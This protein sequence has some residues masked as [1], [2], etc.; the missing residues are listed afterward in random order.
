MA[1]VYLTCFPLL[2]FTWHVFR[3]C[4]LLDMFSMAVVY[5]TCF[6]WLWFTWHVFCCCGLL[7]MFS[8]AVVYLTCF[9]WLWFTWHVFCCCGLLDMFSVAVVY[10]TCFPWLRFTWHVFHGCGLLDMFSVAVV[11][12]TCFPWLWFTGLVFHGCVAESTA[13]GLRTRRPSFSACESWSVSS[14]SMTTSTQ[15]ELS[16]KHP[17]LR[18][19][20]LPSPTERH[21]QHKTTYNTSC[22]QTHRPS[23]QFVTPPPHHH[24]PL[25]QR[26]T[27]TTHHAHKHTGLPYSLCDTP[28]P[29]STLEKGKFGGGGGAHKFWSLPVLMPIFSDRVVPD[30]NSAMKLNKESKHITSF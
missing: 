26:K 29:P 2:W 21:A 16:P 30:N 10:W 25:S 5:L 3:C 22:T 4:G 18:W 13:R 7:D 15:W 27:H 1:V 9:P 14:S 23:L 28:P 8:V 17:A 12:L 19:E 24:L 6:S 11:Y 20:L